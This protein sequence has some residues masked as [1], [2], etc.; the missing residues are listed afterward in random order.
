MILLQSIHPVD[1]KEPNFLQAVQVNLWPVQLVLSKCQVTLRVNHLQ[2]NLYA[3]SSAII[4]SV[5]YS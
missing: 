1:Y 2:P 5:C 4:N 3:G